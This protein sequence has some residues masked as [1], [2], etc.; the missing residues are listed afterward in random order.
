VHVRVERARRLLQKGTSPA[1]VAA[2]LGFADQS[3]F[4]RHF[5]RIMHVT[6]IQYARTVAGSAEQFGG[7]KIAYCAHPSAEDR[8]A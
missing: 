2:N 7:T 3:H 1:I 5:K 8:Y 6:P 4:G